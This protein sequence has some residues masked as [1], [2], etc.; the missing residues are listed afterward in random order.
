[1]EREE[2]SDRYLR[3]KRNVSD[4]W[5]RLLL[6]V[7][8]VSSWQKYKEWLTVF[9]LII[10]MTIFTVWYFFL[11]PPRLSFYLAVVVT[12]I[13]FIVIMTLQPKYRKRL[14]KQVSTQQTRHGEKDGRFYR[15]QKAA[16]AIVIVSALL[17]PA[18]SSLVSSLYVPYFVL[19]FITVVLTAGSVVIAGIVK[20]LG[21]WGY[22][23][24]AGV[25]MVVVL[26]VLAHLFS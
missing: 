7:F 16:L 23:L 21:K 8:L 9:V 2:I 22:M 10:L 19:A 12:A 14:I 18:V 6:V 3:K 24:L 15:Y 17:F 1:M 5:R 25:V 26:L 13:G 20:A 11:N 4:S